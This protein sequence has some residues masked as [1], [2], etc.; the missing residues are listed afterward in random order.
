VLYLKVSA[1]AKSQIIW[2]QNGKNSL[3]VYDKEDHFF[4]DEVKR[5]WEKINVREAE[6][7]WEWQGCTAYG[8]G[9]FNFRGNSALSHRIAMF[10]HLK[11]IL[12]SYIKVLHDCDNP[13]CCNPSH[14]FLGTDLSNMQDC[15]QKGRQ[16]KGQKNHYAILTEEQALEIKSRINS[17]ESTPSIHKDYLWITRETIRRIGRGETWR[18]LT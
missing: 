16:C 4:K 15:A 7:C 12:P 11:L 13:P 18:H 6:Q 2:I 17:G 9:R 14:L 1:M 5:F 8:Y 3:I 10:L